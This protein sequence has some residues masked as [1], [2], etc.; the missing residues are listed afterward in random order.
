MGKEE[1]IVIKRFEGD[2]K[3]QDSRTLPIQDLSVI[4]GEMTLDKKNTLL[5]M[6]DPIAK[7]LSIHEERFRK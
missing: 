2:G 6:P 4:W 3:S 7:D 5:L 1:M